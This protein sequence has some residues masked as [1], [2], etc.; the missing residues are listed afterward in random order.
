[1]KMPLRL[2]IAAPLLLIGCR[3]DPSGDRRA[4]EM[5][6]R[7]VEQQGKQNEANARQGQEVA[8]ASRGLVEADA[9]ART[10]M[11]ENPAGWIFTSPGIR[12]VVP[13]NRITDEERQALE[14]L[15]SGVRTEQAEGRR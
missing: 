12:V 15:I 9:Q 6:S 14:V 10:K 4:A 8:A 5:A 2:L 7:F 13:R 3:G 1:M 11:I